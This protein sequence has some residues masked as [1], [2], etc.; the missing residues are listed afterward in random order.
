MEQ[1]LTNG[2]KER[3]V[4]LLREALR[5]MEVASAKSIERLAQRRGSKN[6]VLS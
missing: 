4:A 2:E 6:T 5:S 1:T 3:V